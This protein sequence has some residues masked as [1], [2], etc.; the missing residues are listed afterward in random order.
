MSKRRI[1]FGV[2]A[3]LAVVGALGV[4]ASS[5]LYVVPIIMYHQVYDVG[6]RRLD[7][8]SLRLFEWQMAYIKKNRFHV[9][10]LKKL[11]QIIKEGKP[12]PR[13]SVVIT[14]DDGYE[15]NYWNAFP[16]LRKYQF[17]A[18]IFMV[19]DFIDVPGYLTREQLREMAAQGID[20]AS[21]TRTH[22]YLPSVSA[23]IASEQIRKSKER[24]EQEL[25]IKV[26]HFSYPSGG[27]NEKIKFLVQEA[28]YESACT[29]NRG[30]DRFMHDP[31]ELKRIRLSDADNRMD[32]LW[33]KLSGFYNLFRQARSPD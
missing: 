20:I 25:G 9:L 17:P 23:E 6:H 26:S 10:P 12:L 18:T 14:F 1:F 24:L 5:R 16:I 28:G 21:H 30:Y 2:L 19:S 4:W 3:V 11:V 22:A 13:K 8:V 32:Y 7:T 15:N 27:F 33:M 29:T 31:Y